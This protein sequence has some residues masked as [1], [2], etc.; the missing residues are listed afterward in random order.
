[1]QSLAQVLDDGELEAMALAIELR[2]EVLL[3]DE[4]LGRQAAGSLGI[5]IIGTLGIL[6]RAKQAGRIENARPLI[7]RLRGELGFFVSHE[8]YR[9]FL[10]TMGE[11]RE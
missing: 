6:G 3:I 9:H 8:L 4:A 7:D 2:A 5:P 10:K 1:V 11:W